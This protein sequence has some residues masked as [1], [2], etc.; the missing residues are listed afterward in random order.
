MPSLESGDVAV[1]V[2]LSVAAALF[3]EMVPTVNIE[4]TEGTLILPEVQ[5]EVEV[6]EE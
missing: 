5:A 1:K 2:K 3:E 6:Q 4:L